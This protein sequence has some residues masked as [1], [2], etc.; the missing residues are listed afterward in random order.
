MA[1][2][3]YLVELQFGSSPYVDVS[4]YVQNISISKGISRALEDYPAGSISI[5]FVNNSRIFDP[6]NTSSPLW[7]G[8]GGYTLVQPAG[9]IRVSAN[10][11]RK[12]TGTVQDWDFSYNESGLDGRA[13]VTALDALY[14]VSNTVFTGGGEFL[15]QSTSERIQKVMNFNGFGA[16][17]YAGVIGGHTLVGTEALESGENILSYLQNVARSEPADFFSNASGVMQLRDRSFTN[18]RWNNTTRNNFVIYPSTAT[19]SAEIDPFLASGWVYGGASSTAPALFGGTPN[20]ATINSS[21]NRFEMR[22]SENKVEKYNP[23]GSTTYNLTFSAWFRGQGLVNGG[24]TGSVDLLDSGGNT[25]Q[26]V[27]ISATALASTTWVQSTFSTFF[28]GGTVAGVNARIYSGGTTSIY[29]FIADGWFIEQA[30]G[31]TNYFDGNY[32]PFVS[33]TSTAY[34]VAWSGVPYQSSSGLLTSVASAIA[35][36]ALVTFADQNS[37]G[38][39]FGN[40][41]GIPF[42]SL[43][44]TYG[45]EQLHNKVQVLGVNATAVVEDTASQILYGLLGYAQQDN[46]TTS[47]TKPAEI[48]ST[49]LA[50]YRLPE[51]RAS[52]ITVT[53][54]PLSTADQNRLIALD[55]RDV[56]RVCFQPSATGAIVDKYYQIL[57]ISSNADPERDEITFSLAS[58]DNLP[59]RLDSP[60]IGLLDTDTLG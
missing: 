2:P 34:E 25:L 32:N 20:Q 8:A 19:V 22:F 24:L 47:T 37:Q 27:A 28:S 9:R 11:I 38:T 1:L 5:T 43:G 56:V 15:V 14:K 35:T 33:S 39:A 17:E 18:Y 44:I 53:L 48:A 31:Y 49:L 4:Q 54:D 30:S 40:G 57:A 10:G 45:S 13:T 16:S 42:T 52:E 3:T 55:L 21:F 6:L 26:T 60:F 41:T 46:L 12:F 59:L 23:Y 58:L 51:Y 50:E 29:S 7:Y 36:P